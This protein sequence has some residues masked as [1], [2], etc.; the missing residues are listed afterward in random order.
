MVICQIY[1]ERKQYVV[2]CDDRKIQKGFAF[3]RSPL[4]M[5]WLWN[6]IDFIVR[7]AQIAIIY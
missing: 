3:L 1:T 7:L 4:A 5:A 2:Q 6:K